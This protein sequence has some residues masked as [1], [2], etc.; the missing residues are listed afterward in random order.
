MIKINLKPDF[1]ESW[2]IRAF[3]ADEHFE[4]SRFNVKV[5][6]QLRRKFLLAHQTVRV[7]RLDRHLL[8]LID[9]SLETEVYF[10]MLIY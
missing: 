3:G 7:A 10:V 1:D 8:R 4:V 9:E 6:V 5:Q 2:E